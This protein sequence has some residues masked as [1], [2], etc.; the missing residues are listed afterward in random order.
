MPYRTPGGAVVAGRQAPATQSV[1]RQAPQYIPRLSFARAL[2]VASVESLIQI[3]LIGA[4]A[5]VVVGL[6]VQIAGAF[7]VGAL[8]ASVGVHDWVSNRELSRQSRSEAP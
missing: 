5:A 1:T 6:V 4:A 2:E 7:L 3:V 8:T